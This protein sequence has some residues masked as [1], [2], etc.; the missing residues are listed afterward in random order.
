MAKV[1]LITGTKLK[2]ALNNL[3]QD[4]LVG[5]IADI[6]KACPQAKEYLTIKFAD[7]KDTGEIFESYKK[8]VEHEFFPPRGYGRLNLREA[9]KAISDFKKICSDKKLWIDLMLF[10]VENCVKFDRTYGG[11]IGESFYNSAVSM[12]DNVVKEI[13]SADMALYLLFT[14]RLK[15]AA[16]NA[17]HGWG[18][19]DEMM[20]AYHSIIWLE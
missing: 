1:N 6:A 8:K 5:L 20:E 3:P 10:Y 15:S 12:Y 13:N 17:P 16:D 14:A 18:F 2:R 9:K 11:D 7:E 19:N 4:E